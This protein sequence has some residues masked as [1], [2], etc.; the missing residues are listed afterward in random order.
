MRASGSSGPWRHP[1]PLCKLM[2]GVLTPNLTCIQPL[3]YQA[4]DTATYTEERLITLQ[5]PCIV[6]SLCRQNV[7]LQQ[8]KV[9]EIFTLRQPCD[10]YRAVLYRH[11]SGSDY[12]SVL[13][14]LIK[15]NRMLTHAHSLLLAT[16]SPGFPPTILFRL[17]S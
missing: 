6:R 12:F 16:A 14:C 13:V 9:T 7:L 15:V 4:S 8:L 2:G 10:V 1:H 11:T 3:E 5:P 17:N